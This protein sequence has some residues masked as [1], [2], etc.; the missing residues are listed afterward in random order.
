MIGWNA[1]CAKDA[2]CANGDGWGVRGS[3]GLIDTE[4][5][6]TGGA[7]RRPLCGNGAASI[8]P[9]AWGKIGCNTTL[10]GGRP[11]ARTVLLSDEAARTMDHA[12][13]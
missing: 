9:G 2:K 12:G 13:W 11:L 5:N 3:R 6:G 4:F 10:D 7:S 8:S 1:K